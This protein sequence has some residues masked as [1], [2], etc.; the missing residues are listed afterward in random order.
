MPFAL[1]TRR[2]LRP[3]LEDVFSGASIGQ[4]GLF[5]REAVTATWQRYIQ[6]SDNRDWS[7][8]WSLGILIASINRS[9]TAPR[10]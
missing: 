5:N 3:F 2:E 7:R 10:A 6:G 9:R 4:S 8:I 1:W